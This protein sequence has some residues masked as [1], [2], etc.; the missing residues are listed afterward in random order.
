MMPCEDFGGHGPPLYFAHANGYP[1]ACYRP[2]FRH[3]G[4]AFHVLAFHQRPLWPKAQPRDLHDW[5]PLADDLNAFFAA[6]NGPAACVG[7]SMGGVATLRAA[8]RR[9][10]QY[11]AIV[12]LD[13]VLIPPELCLLWEIVYR[14]GLAYRFSPL[15]PQALRR[16]R[17]FKGHTEM[18]TGYRRK[19]I[20]RYFSDE[21]LQALVEGL[22]RPSANGG[23]ELAYPPEW[24]ARIYVTAHRR[25]LE[26][27]RGLPGLKVPAMILRGAET[28]T[29]WE[30]TAQLVKRRAPQIHIVTLSQ[31]THL[32]PLEKPQDVA[33]LIIDFIQTATS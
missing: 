10:E 7:H 27:W 33:M 16:R 4:E 25:N 24:E 18:F 20:F 32:L 29:F 1:P 19:T 12:L 6:Q 8:L 23:L 21:S 30:R 22:T 28:D 14:L 17:T 11:Q 2:L 26:L 9:P 3:L 13:P 15:V 5:R 31:C